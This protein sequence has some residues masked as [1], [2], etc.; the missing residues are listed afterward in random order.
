MKVGSGA[1]VQDGEQADLGG[2]RRGPE[3]ELT[4]HNVKSLR[5]ALIRLKKEV[6]MTLEEEIDKILMDT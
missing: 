3:S 6:M 4:R 1:V 2:V 5:P